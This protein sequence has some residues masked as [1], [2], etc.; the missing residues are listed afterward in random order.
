M[1]DGTGTG[2]RLR[3]ARVLRWAGDGLRGFWIGTADLVP[4]VSGSTVAV[5]LGVYERLLRAVR[6]AAAAVSS[7]IRGDVRGAARHLRRI[8]WRLVIPVGT[9]IGVA[10]GVLAGAV[11]WLL[12]NRAEATAGAFAGLVC[13]AV[14]AAARQ[15]RGRRPALAALSL[16]VAVAG[17]WVFGLTAEPVAEP[18]A[19]L[20][21]GAGTLGV[22]A[23]ILPGVSGA[24]VLL[25]VGVYAPFIDALSGRHWSALGLAAGGAVVGALAFSS[26][27][28]RLLDRHHDAVMAVMVGLMGGSLRVLW[29]WPNGVGI[30][31]GPGEVISGTGLGLPDRSEVLWPAVCAVVAFGLALAVSRTA[32]RGRSGT[33]GTAAENGL[34]EAP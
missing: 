32:D 34:L 21:F 16:A 18:A 25:M 15:V 2:Q 7:L 19:G 13:A 6:S 17:G 12:T 14:I 9:G 1:S 22:C 8:D 20:W 24:F 23:M 3:G 11:D 31:G 29:P 28:S 5:L 27:L 4:G 10:L 26:L 33:A 30:L